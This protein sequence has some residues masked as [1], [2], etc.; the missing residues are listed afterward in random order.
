VRAR[1]G[2]AWA[3]GAVWAVGVLGLRS[4]SVEAQLEIGLSGSRSTLNE[5]TA[6][7]RQ[8]G[9]GAVGSARWL[10]SGWGVEGSVSWESLSAQVD[11][12]RTDVGYVGGAVRA[13]YDVWRS[14][15]VQVGFDSRTADPEFAAQDVAALAVG[16]LYRVP[17][18]EPARLWIRGAA[19][20][21]A[22]LSGGGDTSIGFD[23]GFGA[24]V[25][26]PGG[27]WGLLAEY[28]F[29]RIDRTVQ[30]VEAPIQFERLRFGVLL[31][32]F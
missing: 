2:T 6:N 20:P 16:L 12:T 22:W 10:G 27:R 11:D 17:L 18:A 28:E 19:V 25:R 24:R 3:V 13:H 8:A 7:N 21:K 14:L 26:P 9:F 32:A 31:A 5:V 1:L 29:Q 30:E 15:A 23:V 4:G